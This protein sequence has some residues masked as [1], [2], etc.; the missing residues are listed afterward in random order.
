MNLW[1][2]KSIPVVKELLDY[3]SE[4]NFDRVIAFLLL[5]FHLEQ[6]R[7]LIRKEAKQKV[8]D[9]FFERKFGKDLNYVEQVIADMD[10]VQDEKKESFINKIKKGEHKPLLPGMFKNMSRN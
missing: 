3:N 5:I 10:D 8:K 1:R 6:I 9:R 7:A 2:I 4:G